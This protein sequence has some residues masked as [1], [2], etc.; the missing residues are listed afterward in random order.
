MH[1]VTRCTFPCSFHIVHYRGSI[2]CEMNME[3]FTLLQA[4]AGMTVFCHLSGTLAS[5]KMFDKRLKKSMS[6]QNKKQ[7]RNIIISRLND[8]LEDENVMA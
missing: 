4:A 8:V 6:D 3:M 2:Q 7:N 5:G 1:M